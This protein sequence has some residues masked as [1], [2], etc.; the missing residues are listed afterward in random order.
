[1]YV[2]LHF[3]YRI[4]CIVSGKQVIRN[5][6]PGEVKFNSSV[7]INRPKL[8]SQHKLLLN[9]NAK[10]QEIFNDYSCNACLD[11]MER[12]LRVHKVH[13]NKLSDR[14]I[15][16]DLQKELLRNSVNSE[17]GHKYKRD[18]TAALKEGTKKEKRSKIKKHKHQ[19]TVAVTK[20][21]LDNV[22]YALQV[23]ENNV[24]GD[25]ET[26]QVYT[27]KKHVPCD[28]PEGKLLMD[29]SKMKARKNLKKPNEDEEHEKEDHDKK[30]R[31]SRSNDDV[32]PY[33]ETDRLEVL[34]R[35]REVDDG[36]IPENVM[37][38]VEDFY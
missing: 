19:K 21:A 6:K 29:V 16:D 27:V 38:S 18:V 28:T 23:K 35:R 37:S 9:L 30:Q 8:S 34:N 3:K 31:K 32:E 14:P 1:M 5:F 12:A 11:C 36:Q 25:I 17:H 20:Y 7:L 2:Y 13:S 24:S 26:C 10:L 15:L 4:F 22:T 33:S